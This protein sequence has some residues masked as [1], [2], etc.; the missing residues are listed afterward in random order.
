MCW[1]SKV[2]LNTF[3]FSLFGI[4]FAYFNNVINI[5]ELLY[6]FSFISMQLV[7]YFTWENLNNTKINTLLSKIGAFLIFIQIPLFIQAKYTGPYKVGLFGLYILLYFLC[8]P[9]FK[10]DYS[11]TKASNGHL[12][13]NW[14]NF[15]TWINILWLSFIFG[16]L[17]YEKRYISFIIYFIII[18]TIYYTYNKTKTWGSLWCWIANIISLRLIAQVFY[19][20]FCI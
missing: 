13:W 16:I 15:P 18:S 4:S 14:L 7:E 19:K 11:M 17:F 2:S 10:I 20:D 6:L 8:I 1:N 3:L 5:Y 12:A 9:N